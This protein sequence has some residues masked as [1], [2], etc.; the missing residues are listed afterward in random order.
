MFNKTQTE[1]ATMG[2]SITAGFLVSGM[3]WTGTSRIQPRG[4]PSL[5]SEM[6]IVGPAASPA[7]FS[8]DAVQLLEPTA[9]AWCKDA[10][11]PTET[12]LEWISPKTPPLHLL[13][14]R[15]RQ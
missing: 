13:D 15:N 1:I 9:K 5:S 4:F 3:L 10:G 6:G 8:S 2:L 14:L 7:Q 12:G 11:A